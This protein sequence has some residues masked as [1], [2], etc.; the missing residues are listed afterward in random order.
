MAILSPLIESLAELG[1][2]GEKERVR[3]ERKEA[4]RER[5]RGERKE[6]KYTY[7]RREECH[8]LIPFVQ[9]LKKGAK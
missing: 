7:C 6:V 3:K 8:L 1:M 2:E 9:P 5:E 4:E